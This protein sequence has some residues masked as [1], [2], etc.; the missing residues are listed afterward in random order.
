MGSEISNG[1]E[2]FH[3]RVIRIALTALAALLGS[4]IVLGLVQANVQEWAKAN[5]QDQYLVKYAGPVVDR[6]A[7]ITQS[8]TFIAIAWMVIGG[9]TILWIDY[10]LRRRTN[11]MAAFLY[12][13]ALALAG[14]ATWITFQA[15]KPAEA[16]ANPRAAT[17]SSSK[18]SFI[19][20]PVLTSWTDAK[21]PLMFLG[22]P[23]MTTDRLRVVVEY[24]L[25]RV[26]WMSPVRFE[27]DQVKEP[28]KGK[29][30]TL[31]MAHAGTKQNGGLE[32][33]WWGTDPRS[34]NLVTNNPVYEN[35]SAAALTRGRI[36]IIGPDNKEQNALYFEIVR[37]LNDQGGNIR[38][39]VLH[40]PEVADWI[41]EW[42]KAN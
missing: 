33:L 18:G 23:T 35:N 10:A 3:R 7:E 28:I 36:V 15:P 6:L 19:K 31:P 37:G 32:D 41:S 39:R 40:G 17:G 22:T 9:A 30:F 2:Q 29:R 25:Y 16:E 26:G 11:K 21:H 8:A 1:K 12:I 42:E 13:S 5:E 24:S 20:E 27:L 14:I 4:G 34:D 38:F